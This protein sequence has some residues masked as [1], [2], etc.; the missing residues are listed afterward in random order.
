MS[1]YTI[2]PEDIER[3]KITTGT[4][5]GRMLARMPGAHDAYVKLLELQSGPYRDAAGQRGETVRFVMLAART[6]G[7]VKYADWGSMLSETSAKLKRKG[8]ATQKGLFP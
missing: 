3:Y 1:D 5:T 7:A 2:K 4:V 8:S 6:R